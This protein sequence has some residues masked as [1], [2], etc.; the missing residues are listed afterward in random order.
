MRLVP[1]DYVEAVI[2]PFVVLNHPSQPQVPMPREALRD[3]ES[4]AVWPAS[5]MVSH[6][7]RKDDNTRG[8]YR[9][10]ESLAGVVQCLDRNHIGMAGIPLSPTAPRE[11]FDAIAGM[12]G[13]LFVNLRID[14]HEGMR[15]VRRIDELCEAYPF[16]RAISLT[17]FQIYPFIPPNSKEYYPIYTK[18]VERSLAAFVNVGFPGPRVPAWVQDP[19]H[20]DEVCWF[21]PE[22]TVVMRHGGL[23]WVDTCVQMLLRW[24]NLYYATTAIAPR[25]WPQQIV[26]YVNTRGAEK[27][28]FAGYWPL[29]SYERVFEEASRLEISGA[30]W[31]KLLAE[32]ATKAFRLG[33][34]GK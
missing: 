16:I 4:L 25:Y 1:Q 13:R 8:R 9:E 10:S 17:P 31:P 7:F 30:A 26:D 20:L 14:P 24:P 12:E 22:L 27:V 28:I 33:A 21:F 6:L 2:D 34:E 19:I 11:L 32:N 15:A 18:C 29:L 5:D 3:D 23:P